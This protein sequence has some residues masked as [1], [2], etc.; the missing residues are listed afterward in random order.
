MSLRNPVVHAIATFLVTAVASCPA[1]SALGQEMLPRSHEPFKGHIGRTA[2]DSSPDIRK[3]VAPRKNAPNILLI[4]TD[5]VA[6]MSKAEIVLEI[7]VLLQGTPLGNFAR[8]NFIAH[9][10]SAV[11]RCA[12]NTTLAMAEGQ[13]C[14]RGVA[15]ALRRYS[16]RFTK[17]QLG[18]LADLYVN[19]L[20]NLEP[21][22][23]VRVRDR[24][25]D[26][27]S[28]ESQHD[29]AAARAVCERLSMDF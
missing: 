21:A 3:E 27:S 14:K 20:D 24:M 13:A 29:A 19:A 10:N 28:N 12:I 6:P 22:A 18:V 23:L 17:A 9:G 4:L 8:E 15:T 16:Y 7:I 11:V 25:C 2:K 26:P 1:F 5:D